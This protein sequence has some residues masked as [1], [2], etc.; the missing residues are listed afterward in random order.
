MSTAKDLTREQFGKWTVLK[1]SGT[2]REGRATWLCQCECGTIREVV[3]KSLISNISKSCGCTRKEAAALASSAKNTKHGMKNTR[4]Y[5]IWHSM[6]GRTLYPSTHSYEIY[7]GKGIRVCKKWKDDFLS[8]ANWAVE[9]GYN[10]TLTLDRI[11]NDKDYC[12]E[13]CR[14]VT[15]KQQANNRRKQ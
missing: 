9:N 1:R 3:G 4:L 11:D 6:K 14:W 13:N 2:N 5:T 7:G 8:F 10:D 15:W 12:P